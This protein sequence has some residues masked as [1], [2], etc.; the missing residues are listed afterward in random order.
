MKKKLYLIGLIFL[1]ITFIVIKSTYAL[2]ETNA[3][4][5]ASFQVGKW[6]IKLNNR[7]ISLD[8]LV[9]LDD[10]VFHN[11]E[12]TEDG[13]FAPGSTGEFELDIDVSESDVSVEYEISIDDS[14]LD[15]YPNIH[16]KIIDLD[17]GNEMISNNT[18]K[19][20]NVKFIEIIVRVE[21]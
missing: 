18:Q 19:E 4:A 3:N 6:V 13:Y 17:T 11:S 21:Y 2:F 20:R 14:S 9:T 10:F 5:D 1:I 12:Y 7:D 8:K 16:F 15:D